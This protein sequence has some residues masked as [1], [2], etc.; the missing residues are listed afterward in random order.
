MITVNVFNVWT[1]GDAGS[2]HAA[3][4]AASAV[5][6]KRIAAAKTTRPWIEALTR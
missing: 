6:H 3:H 4:A 5:S 2:R 1:A